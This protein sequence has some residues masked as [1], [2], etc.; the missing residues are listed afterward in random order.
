MAS[1]GHAKQGETKPRKEHV[2]VLETIY[3]K[4]VDLS[5]IAYCA[6]FSIFV[7]C[8]A[9][10]M[11]RRTLMS[12][13]LSCSVLPRH[14]SRDNQEQRPPTESGLFEYS[15]LF[16][17]ANEVVGGMWLPAPATLRKII[18]RPVR[19]VTVTRHGMSCHD[20]RIIRRDNLLKSR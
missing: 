13:A 5:S 20:C 15:D 9:R 10:D 8:C 4:I 12:M 1:R 17:S 6:K 3:K 11:K 19:P 18:H 2:S 14:C 7:L 16:C